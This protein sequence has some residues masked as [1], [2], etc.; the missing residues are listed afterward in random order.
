MSPFEHKLYKCGTCMY[1][2]GNIIYVEGTVAHP[3]FGVVS[4]TPQTWKR[5]FLRGKSKQNI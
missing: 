5:E 2:L 1:H 3:G 4:Y